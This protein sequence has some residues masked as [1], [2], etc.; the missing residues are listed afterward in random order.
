GIAEHGGIRGRTDVPDEV[1]RWFPTAHEIDVR[2]HVK[3]QAVFQRR[4]H[5]AVSKT[6]NLKRTATPAEVKGAYEL[7]YELGCKGITVY[8]DTSREG[9]VLVTGAR[10]ALIAASP[11]CP[12]CRSTLV[13]QSACRLCRHCGWSVCG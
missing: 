1:Q 5:A 6:I 3:M 11:V 9:Q 4:V 13:V 2:T 8:R 10:S 12:E 7:A